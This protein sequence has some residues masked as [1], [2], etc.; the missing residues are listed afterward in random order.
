MSSQVYTAVTQRKSKLTHCV[1]DRA[2]TIALFPTTM[3]NTKAQGIRN[4]F[5]VMQRKYNRPQHLL[6]EVSVHEIVDLMYSHP[7]TSENP[8]P[9]ATT[10]RASQP[11]SGPPPLQ[12]ISNNRPN[13]PNTV[14]TYQTQVDIRRRKSAAC[15]PN[16]SQ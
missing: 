5:D 10:T 14:N 7:S 13:V 15:H 2:S 8:A 16:L 12:S 11:V 4:A 3:D 9:V 6:K 1:A